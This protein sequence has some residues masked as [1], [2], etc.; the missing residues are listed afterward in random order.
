MNILYVQ[1]ISCT[2]AT[3]KWV[4]VEIRQHQKYICAMLLEKQV[5]DKQ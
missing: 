2:K 3:W 1:C 5:T 4:D